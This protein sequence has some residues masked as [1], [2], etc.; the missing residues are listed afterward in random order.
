MSDSG[1]TQFGRYVLLKRVSVGGTSMVYQALDEAPVIPRTVALKRLLEHCAEDDEFIDKFLRKARLLMV[2]GHANVV[3]VVDIGAV[4]GVYFL[5]TEWVDGH[6]LSDMQ[7]RVLSRG[8]K[9][10]PAPIAVS[11][12]IDICRGL[13]AVH[14]LR[15]EQGRPAEFLYRNIAPNEVL[16]SFEGEVKVLEFCTSHY[17]SYATQRQVGILRPKLQY[18]SPEQVMGAALDAR[19]DVY[20]TGL[21]LY[22]MLCGELPFGVESDFQ[23]L[24]AIRK[25]QLTPV[26]QN[27]PSLDEDLARILQR[28]LKTSPEDRYPSAKALAQA[29]SEWMRAHAPAF[30]ADTRRHWMSWLYEE[31]LARRGPTPPLPP[32]FLEQLRAWRAAALSV[33][34]SPPAVR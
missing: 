33:S 3:R 4:D 23:A 34:P 17:L 13:H 30:R 1:T 8:M 15:D 12:A 10:L 21:V 14:T 5:A 7:R 28:T 20:V 9:W 18:I 22:R 2:L 24:D 29:L 25:G 11:I 27:N 6:L 19:S 16:V 32:A 31:E 26:R